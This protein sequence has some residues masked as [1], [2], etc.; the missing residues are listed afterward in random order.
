MDAARSHDC[1]GRKYEKSKFQWLPTLFQIS[2][3]GKCTI[4][5]YVNNLN[6]DKY[7]ALYTDL[8]CLFEL[9]LPYF[10]EVL[11]YSSVYFGPCLFF[12]AKIFV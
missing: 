1:W 5:E 9:F 7:P 3:D 8:E 11:N 10:E 6:R 4:M 2:E 12:V